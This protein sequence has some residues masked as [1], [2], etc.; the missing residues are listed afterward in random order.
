MCMCVCVCV[1]VS[2]ILNLLIRNCTVSTE[3]DI[4][5]QYSP[6]LFKE[7][8]FYQYYHVMVKYKNTKVSVN[9]SL[10]G[11]FTFINISLTRVLSNFSYASIPTL[12]HTKLWNRSLFYVKTNSFEDTNWR[13]SWFFYSLT[14]CINR[15]EK[16]W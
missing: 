15:I 13:I 12:F 2:W 10:V 8:C 4:S 16:N 1:S 7:I 9:S 14:S 11:I 6:K 3:P 5:C